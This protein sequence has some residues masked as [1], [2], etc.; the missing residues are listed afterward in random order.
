MGLPS[1][2]SSGV[3]TSTPEC[4]GVRGS[5]AHHWLFVTTISLNSSY[6][7]KWISIT[8][9]TEASGNC[10]NM[11]YN[12]IQEMKAGTFSKLT[13]LKWFFFHGN[14]NLTKIEYGSLLTFSHN[15]TFIDL[16]WCNL[17]TFPVDSYNITKPW[18]IRLRSQ[19]QAFYCQSLG[20][21]ITL[22]PCS[23]VLSAAPGIL[24]RDLQPWKCRV[25]AWNRPDWTELTKLSC[26]KYK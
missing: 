22:W 16:R 7:Y 14:F 19:P 24:R 8:E 1:Q 6:D 5:T 3:V 10:L 21:H 15:L 26:H 9:Y 12:D 4:S 2:N 20:Q 23:D 25:N 11:D 18:P 13:S 17:L